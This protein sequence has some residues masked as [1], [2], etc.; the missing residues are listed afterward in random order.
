MLSWL[1]RKW[2]QGCMYVCMYA[3]A[4]PQQRFENW[5]SK[6]QT[7]A[8]KNNLTKNWEENETQVNRI[9]LISHRGTKLTKHNA[10]TT[11]EI[12][13]ISVTGNV[14]SLYFSHSAFRTFVYLSVRVY[15]QKVDDD[16]VCGPLTLLSASSSHET[17]VLMNS[18]FQFFHW[19]YLRKM[20]VSELFLIFSFIITDSLRGSGQESWPI[21]HCNKRL[22]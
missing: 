16:S 22:V 7:T 10:Q 6:I 9:K 3:A 18:A 21:N 15:W 1:N 5:I 11:H 14:T 20:V 8:V 19:T 4:N 13:H 17:Y 12:K 2:S